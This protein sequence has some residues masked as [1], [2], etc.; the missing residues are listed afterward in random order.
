MTRNARCASSGEFLRAG[1]KLHVI[2]GDWPMMIVEPVP[3]EDW[4]AFV[5]RIRMLE[6]N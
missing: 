2:E 4:S 5:Q 6:P 1:G 3:A